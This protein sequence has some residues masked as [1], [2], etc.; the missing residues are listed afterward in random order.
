MLL[1]KLLELQC[2]SRLLDVERGAI[3]RELMARQQQIEKP[4][5]LLWWFGGGQVEQKALIQGGA[6]NRDLD[7]EL[8][9]LHPQLLGAGG[10]ITLELRGPL[11]I[12]VVPEHDT[13]AGQ[14]GVETLVD[15]AGGGGGGRHQRSWR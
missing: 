5:A 11:T 12:G 4:V 10:L 13:L 9:P 14:S 3:G 7:R 15:T 2:Q 8:I 6:A 1:G